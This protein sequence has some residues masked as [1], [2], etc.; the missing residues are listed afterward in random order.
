MNFTYLESTRL[1]VNYFVA[2]TVI[3]TDFFFFGGGVLD[4]INLSHS[5]QFLTMKCFKFQGT[6]GKVVFIVYLVKKRKTLQVHSFI[7]H[8]LGKPFCINT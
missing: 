5:L 4:V 8:L 7:F 2:H 3:K 1:E 6:V